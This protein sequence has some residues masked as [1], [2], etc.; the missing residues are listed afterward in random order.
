MTDK[1]LTDKIDNYLKGKMNAADE[2]IFNQQITADAL[3]KEMVKLRCLEL[4]ALELILENDLR[5]KMQLDWKPEHSSQALSNTN[6]T[7]DS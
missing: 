4:D 7:S 5:K 2:T 6:T 1:V 3:L